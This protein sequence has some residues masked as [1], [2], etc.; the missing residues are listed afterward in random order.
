MYP[1]LELNPGVHVY[2]CDFA[3]TAV[4]LVKAHPAHDPGRVTAFVADITCDDLLRWVPRASVDACTMVFVL[5]AISPV[6]MASAVA[7][8]ARTLEPGRG[9]ILFRDYAEG[10]LAQGRLGGVNRQQKIEEGFYMRGDGTRAYYFTE[11]FA[12]ELFG[13][14]GFRCE[15]MQTHQRLRTNRRTG[16]QMERRFLQAVFVLEDAAKAAAIG[17]VRR[18]P[19]E[20]L[21]GQAGKE[22]AN[23]QLPSTAVASAH[24]Y[25]FYGSAAREGWAVDM[26]AAPPCTVAI[27]PVTLT[28]R[29]PDEV[30]VRDLEEGAPALTLARLVIACPR[31]FLGKKVVE[32]GCGAAGLPTLAAL[33]WCR[34]AVATDARPEAIAALRRNAIANGH[35]FVYERFRVQHVPDEEH[36][37]DARASIGA[38]DAVLCA[39]P[40]AAKRLPGEQSSIE[41]SAQE[42]IKKLMKQA[43]AFLRA[44]REAFILVAAPDGLGAV[45]EM[46]AAGKG[47]RPLQL[48]LGME[49]ALKALAC[50]GV[51]I[52]YLKLT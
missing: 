48:P 1:L 13:D 16:V 44:N 24:K 5:S 11:A 40:A 14:L 18:E 21:P 4:N 20:S 51:D 34:R 25:G 41:G 22:G 43:G 27:G 36:W 49:A 8:V 23:G 2:A 50:H 37:R 15:S 10:D 29:L 45:V 35:K 31:S 32:I 52:I 9:R 28:L 12:M 42:A 30:F 7:N 47:L 19:E 38:A 39:I 26:E 3:P 17:L 46:V 6:A 33:R